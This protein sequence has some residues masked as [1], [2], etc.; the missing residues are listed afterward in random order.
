MHY[1][2]D[3]DTSRHVFLL[4]PSGKWS[5]FEGIVVTD[6]EVTARRHTAAN[7]G[8]TT[9]TEVTLSAK[10][11]AA[12]QAASLQNK[13]GGKEGLADRLGGKAGHSK[14]QCYICMMNA[15]SLTT[16]EQH[17]N[18]KHDKLGPFDPSK[19]SDKQKEAGGTTKGVAIRGSIKK[20]K[21]DK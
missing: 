12:R 3:G 1:E 16:M 8:R 10:D 13:G 14:F 4:A 15:P 19:F 9:R 21:K 11:L 20:G 5:L 2:I 7:S 6:H 17:W 18:S